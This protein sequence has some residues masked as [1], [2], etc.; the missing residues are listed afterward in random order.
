MSDATVEIHPM[1]M[2]QLIAVKGG[3]KFYLKTGM[4]IN[5]AYTPKRMLEVARSFTGKKYAN[6]RKG[7]EA[8]MADLD[9]IHRQVVPE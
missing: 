9:H 4:K 5:A 1:T 7:L 8:A 3:I 2:I 6:S